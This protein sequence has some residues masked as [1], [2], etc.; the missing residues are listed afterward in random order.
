MDSF[1]HFL[2]W[3]LKRVKQIAPETWELLLL[4]S[5]NVE[6]DQIIPVT[7]LIVL[8]YKKLHGD[9]DLTTFSKRAGLISWFNHYGRSIYNIDEL[10]KILFSETNAPPKLKPGGV[11]LIGYNRG[12]LGL[13]EDIRGYAALLD[14]MKVDYSIVHIGHPTDDPINYTHPKEGPPIFDRSLFFLNA[15]ELEKLVKLYNN[16]D[17]TFGR[18]IAVPPWELDKAPKEWFYILSHFEEVWGISNFVTHA[19]EEV[20]HSTIY[21]APIVLPPVI[22]EMHSN[23][24]NKP[25]RF[26]FIFDAGSFIERKN[27]LAVVKAFQSAFSRYENVELVIKVSNRSISP[28]WNEVEQKAASD[29]RI[30][31]VRGLI[32]EEELCQLWGT[33]NCYVSLHRCE[34]FGR[35]IADAV[36]RKLPV[37]ATNYSGSTDL[38]PEGY[39]LLVDYTLVPIE[40]G[41]YPLANE[42]EWASV[43]IEDAAKKMK[44]VYENRCTSALSETVLLAYEHVQQ[45]FGLDNQHRPLKKWL[46]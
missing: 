10:E 7:N 18:A 39:E 8:L 21:S 44:F 40:V 31:L 36:L 27:P 38:F 12:Q 32:T 26:L 23:E 35:T 6:Q 11:N 19:L 46:L 24:S 15:I 41:Q 22:R 14:K 37:I 34:G 30:K 2:P 25:F 29:R 13:G 20:H 4:P 33:A 43:S 1:N 9:V 5:Q 28:H 3:T 16:F 45:K 42:A 17:S